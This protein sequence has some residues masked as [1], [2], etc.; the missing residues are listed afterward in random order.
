[1]RKRERLI[2]IIDMPIH[3]LMKLG[4]KR[5]LKILILLT[6]HKRLPSAATSFL[7][8]AVLR[9]FLKKCRNEPGSSRILKIPVLWEGREET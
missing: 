7:E 5:H 2:L 4:K 1:M 3:N 9:I 8:H 6:P